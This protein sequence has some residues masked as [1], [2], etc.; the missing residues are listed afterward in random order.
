MACDR[1]L[2]AAGCV[3]ADPHAAVIMGQFNGK[4]ICGTS[5]EQSFI[6]SV[7]PDM[8]GECPEDYAACD[9]KS[10]PDNIICMKK[11]EDA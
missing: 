3:Q 11:Q 5:L 1:N 10:S 7:R 9:P 2:T 6:N 4:R 8:N